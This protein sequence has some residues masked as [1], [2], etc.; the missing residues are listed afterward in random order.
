MVI[1]DMTKTR[2][3]ISK[4]QRRLRRAATRRARRIAD[5]RRAELRKA[6]HAREARA[7]AI[8]NWE[9]A[10]DTLPNRPERE[11][12]VRFA[13]D[14]QVATIPDG[15]KDPIAPPVVA[16]IGQPLR[17]E[18]NSSDDDLNTSA[19]PSQQARQMLRAL[20]HNASCQVFEE[21]GDGAYDED[22]DPDFVPT[23]PD[24]VTADDD[25]DD[26]DDHDEV[27]HAPAQR[28]PR[29]IIPS[30]VT[31]GK[32][33]RAP[34][35]SDDDGAHGSD[36]DAD[37]DADA[38]S[39]DATRAAAEGYTCSSGT[40]PLPSRNARKK[41]RR[42]TA[43]AND[44]RMDQVGGKRTACIP[45]DTMDDTNVTDGNN[46]SHGEMDTNAEG[47]THGDKSDD[48]QD[49][50]VSADGQMTE[51]VM[52]GETV[53]GSPSENGADGEGKSAGALKPGK[54]GK[55]KAEKNGKNAKGS[56][57][58]ILVKG[59]HG[60][61]PKKG[62]AEEGGTENSPSRSPAK[63]AVKSHSKSP[64]SNAATESASPGK[65]SGENLAKSPVKTALKSSA[66]NS[67]KSSPGM[68]TLP[69]SSPPKTNSSVGMENGVK[70]SPT[71]IGKPVQAKSGEV[72]GAD[73]T[74]QTNKSSDG[75]RA[76]LDAGTEED[77]DIDAMFAGLS[78]AK[79]ARRVSN[80]RGANVQD[81]D[82]NGT[83]SKDAAGTNTKRT[84]GPRFTEEGFRIMSYDDIK[85][86]QPNGL[87][88][89][90]PFD[91]SC[92]F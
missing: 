14:L 77:V 69:K 91:C 46:L 66:R 18:S 17:P 79:K 39:S 49:E 1:V 15:P 52:N 64:A 62:N 19:D 11:P 38:D 23:D 8:A 24:A 53:N 78:K 58:G 67:G 9:R 45:N 82:V 27:L 83:V 43:L 84:Q 25:D 35:A 50:P 56:K 2:T 37:A 10:E 86:D 61:I 5:A 21:M 72:N 89:K 31:V 54:N 70:S 57:S 33:P 36:S 28:L 29:R 85:A 20:I 3:R 55:R 80:E 32:R 71:S 22:A 92:C 75:D 26:D 68:A 4:R 73:G 60:K 51:S 74:K 47:M 13:T 59:S 16:P 88:G 87:N 76:P 81:G 34:D 63:N 90:C 44:R 42:R 41:K 7:R 65:N 48:M 30:R 6:E 12:R 40:P